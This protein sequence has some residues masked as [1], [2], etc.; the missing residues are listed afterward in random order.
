MPSDRLRQRPA[1]PAVPGQHR[2]A[3]VGQRDRVRLCAGG[4][5]RG[6]SGREDGLV[7][8]VRVGFDRVPGG[9][10]RDRDLGGPE[11]VVPGSDENRLCRRG[12]LVDGEDIHVPP[13]DVPPV[14]PASE[15]WPE[16]PASVPGIVSDRPV[17]SM[18]M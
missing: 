15:G 13:A 1:G 10:D 14:A 2:L 7:E 6:T 5:E 4:P 8:L 11:H 17:A 18:K 9:P 3:L 16:M 12:A